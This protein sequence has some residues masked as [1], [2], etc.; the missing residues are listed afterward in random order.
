[1][2][3]HEKFF[4]ARSVYRIIDHLDWTDEYVYRD[5]TF[6]HEWWMRAETA[7]GLKRESKWEGFRTVVALVPLAE[8]GNFQQI[9]SK[10]LELGVKNITQIL[11]FYEEVL[12]RAKVRRTIFGFPTSPEDM[13]TTAPQYSYEELLAKQAELALQE[14]LSMMEGSTLNG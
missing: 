12:G 1:M 2:S 8:Q 10:I 7:L 5:G 9:F 13:P 4:N 11:G 6:E 3:R 14:L